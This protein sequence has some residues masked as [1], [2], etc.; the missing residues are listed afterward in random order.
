MRRG[1]TP[2]YTFELNII[3]EG[4]TDLNMSFAQNGVIKLEKSLEDVEIQENRLTI[5]LTEDET[6]LFETNDMKSAYVDVQVKF[7]FGTKRA[8]SDITQ[9]IVKPIL[10]EGKL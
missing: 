4:L 6:L 8:I 2:T 1:S 7:G 5:E 3:P 9:I 10:K